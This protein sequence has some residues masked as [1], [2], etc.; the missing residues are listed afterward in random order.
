MQLRSAAATF[1]LIVIGVG[2]ALPAFGANGAHLDDDAD[3]DDA[4]MSPAVTARIASVSTNYLT[5]STSLSVGVALTAGPAGAS[6]IDSVFAVTASPLEDS[7]AVDAFLD[8]PQ[9]VPARGIGHAQPAEFLQG[10][11]QAIGS[12]GPGSTGFASVTVDP[13]TLALPRGTTGVY[14][15][16]V[17]TS[18]D[19]VEPVHN[20]FVMTW[21]D[22]SL[23]I[24]DTAIV[25]TI[26]GSPERTQALLTAASDDRVALLVD[27]TALARVDG[28]SVDPEER[29]VYA[30]PAG[31][32]DLASVV[33]AGA[34]PLLTYSLERARINQPADLPWIAV[35]ATIDSGIVDYVTANAATA[36][37]AGTRLE[38]GRPADA[39]AV[40]ELESESGASV[41]TV[42]ANERLSN[43]LASALRGDASAAARLVAESAL[44]AAQSPLDDERLVTVISPG[45]SWI[46][47]GTRASEEITALFAVPWVHAVTLNAV[48]KS[49]GRVTTSASSTM[50][51]TRDV[52]PEV[53][54]DVQ[55]NVS[56]L[57]DLAAAT[58]EPSVI[59]DGPANA[60]L[61]AMS[62]PMRSDAEAR[63]KAIESALA[64]AATVLDQVRVTSGSELTLV[65]SSGNV[66]IT[67]RND[68]TSTVTVVV[69][70]TS[71]SPN[72]V[73]DAQPTAV[74]P[75]GTEQTVLVPVTAVSNDDVAV[76]VALRNEAGATLAVAKTLDVRVRAAWGT[77]ATAVTTAGLVILLLAGLWRTIRRGQRDTRIGPSTEDPQDPSP[78]TASQQPAP[79]AP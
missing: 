38:A 26:S 76:T 77:V 61:A 36:I 50:V 34:T 7:A 48:L 56:R 9:D 14:G 51:T 58:D 32:V 53:V 57:S 35:P 71:R 22:A 44:V 46:V 49:P 11:S 79:R 4:G 19:G 55:Q 64:D 75:P 33:H 73:I 47:D 69:V 10:A 25:A 72:L 52:A 43:V 42:L 62:L 20:A 45:D 12:L 23:P 74:I 17:T 24:M 16:V 29:E 39:A 41:T 21:L 2:L 65:S 3:L 5:P 13:A 66:P 68:L 27:T 63:D 8:A 1:A 37:L 30:L 6:G 59:L 28:A 60:L 78:E 54:L 67:V 18:A 70:M 40:V 15:F 31:H